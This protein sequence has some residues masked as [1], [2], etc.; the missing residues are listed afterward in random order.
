MTVATEQKMA[1]SI[2]IRLLLLVGTD[3]S[4]QTF[5]CKEIQRRV[6]T[7]HLLFTSTVQPWAASSFPINSRRL[8]RVA[9]VTRVHSWKT[10]FCYQEPLGYSVWE[11]RTMLIWFWKC[12]LLFKSSG[13]HSALQRTKSKSPCPSLTLPKWLNNQ[14]KLTLCL[15]TV[16]DFP[17]PWNTV[18]VS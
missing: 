1:C 16:A 4:G 17:M 15:W 5:P 13:C 3:V 8:Y 14:E 18:M 7:M 10:V 11:I 6:W 12:Q 2:W 9:W